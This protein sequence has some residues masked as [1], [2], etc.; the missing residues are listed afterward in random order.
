MH[1]FET[2]YYLYFMLFILI[3]NFIS[4]GEVNKQNV[5]IQNHFILFQYKGRNKTRK[6]TH[7]LASCK[8]RH[9]SE[10]E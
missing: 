6:Q 2:L 10:A 3:F 7:S 8:Q 1:Y 4:E 5:S 9:R